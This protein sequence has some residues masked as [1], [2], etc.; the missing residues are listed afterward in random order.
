MRILKKNIMK[1]KSIFL[2]LTV[3]ALFSCKS[4]AKKALDKKMPLAENVKEQTELEIT[5]ISHATAV[6]EFDETVIYL[7]PTGG[8]HIPYNP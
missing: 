6:L 8:G 3:L 1:I 2:A 4:E 7:D 5:P